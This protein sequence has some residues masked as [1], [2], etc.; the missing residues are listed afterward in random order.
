MAGSKTTERKSANLSAEQMM[1]AIP[2][3]QKRIEELESF[4]IRSVESSSEPALDVLRKKVN[5]TLQDI[6]GGNSIEYE[7]YE[8][9]SFYP[10]YRS[11]SQIPDFYKTKIKEAVLRLQSLIEIFTERI[12]HSEAAAT[13]V[14]AAPSQ[15]TR[16]I[17]GKVF[18]VHGHDDG[19]KDS[20]ARFIEK[21][22]FQAVILHEQANEGRTIIEK[23]VAH[24]EADFAVVLFT[25]D[26]M[27]YQAAQGNGHA[28]PRARQNVVLE[29]GF[30]MGSLGRNRV[31]VLHTGEL[32]M[33][34]DYAGVLY[35]SL[36]DKSW[37]YLL[38]KEMKAS[39][40]DV[41]L[42]RL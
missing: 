5:T 36:S 8:L 13:Q 39:G 21:L 2:R 12:E 9:G 15:R 23:F 7:E 25:P 24:A 16:E 26:D 31:A 14:T 11:V 17:T 28:K 22:G 42:N 3:L 41:D 37:N 34:S 1:A 35:I 40:L 27:G 6:L 10:W 29:L 33:P 20:V 4:D 18:I 32:E 19:V 30:F 38:A